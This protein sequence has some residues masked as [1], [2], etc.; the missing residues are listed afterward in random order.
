MTST[1]E[2]CTQ[3]TTALTIPS[4]VTDMRFTFYGCTSLAA[5]PDMSSANSVTNMSNAFGN[6]TSL[7]GTIE[8]N[9]NPTSYGNCFRNTTKEIYLTG[10]STKLSDLASTA[11]NGNVTVQGQSGQPDDIVIVIGDDNEGDGGSLF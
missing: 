4:S 2:G 11:N 6:C 10:S 5:P 1:F 8:V 9:A 7:T 3:L